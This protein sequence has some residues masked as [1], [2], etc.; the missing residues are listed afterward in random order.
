MKHKCKVVM[1][2][3][4][5]KA[6]NIAFSLMFMMIL[7]ASSSTNVKAAE[8]ADDYLPE[9]WTRIETDSLTSEEISAISA[10]IYGE[11]EAIQPKA[12]APPL[13]SLDIIDLAV[14]EKN[15][16]HVV[17]R[18]IGTSKPGLRFVYWNNRLCSENTSETQYLVGSDRIVYG[19]IRYF[20]TEVYYSTSLTG[21][22]VRVTAKS[23][24]AMNPWNT[25]NASAT[26]TL[27]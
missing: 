26:F 12:P 24:N 4:L 23:T 21:I 5:K 2:Q 25:L 14:D 6:F 20:H 19:Y 3:K 18:E 8:S 10:A 16:I 9:G 27:P 17:T 1:S 22:V 11:D 15:E 7:F 13:T